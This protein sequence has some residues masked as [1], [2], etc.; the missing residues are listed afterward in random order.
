MREDQ[1]LKLQGLHAKLVDVALQEADPEAW[2]GAGVAPKDLTQQDR[3]DRYWCKKNAVATISLAIRIDTL[4]GKVQGYGVAPPK[5][6]D[7]ADAAEE[8]A[9][10]LLDAE[11]SAAE[12][13]AK[14]LLK[15][16]QKKA[17]ADSR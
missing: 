1:Y 2:S 6:D 17:G 12:R 7:P 4:L 11:V 9:A 13:E 8:Q 14:K 16:F 5:Q 3:G 15:Q 10:G